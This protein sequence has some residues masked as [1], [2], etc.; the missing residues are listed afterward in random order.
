[1]AKVS[2]EAKR[3]Y[4]EKIKEHKVTVEQV[5]QREKNLMQTAENDERG[6]SYKKLHLVDESLNLVSS[7][8][9]MNNLSMSLLGIRNDALLN[10][11]RKACYKAIISLE[12]VVTGYLDVPYSDYSEKVEQISA[13][14]DDSRWLMTRKL[15]FAID[16]VRDG[17]GENSKWK[18]AFVE[19]EGRY[20]TVAK[21]LLDLKNFVAKQDPR[22]EGYESRMRHLSLIKDLL[23]HSADGYRQKY[24]LSTG[25]IDDFKLAIHYLGALRRLHILLGDSEEAESIK[26][27]MEVWKAKMEHD[28]KKQESAGTRKV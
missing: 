16:A 10:D 20:A 28:R 2:E 17:F 12:D 21:N 18:W 26:K 13:F 19:I 14:D 23:G 11:A 24:E 6:A 3:R 1:V 25:R 22:I 8:V 5:L 15:G 7:F 9:L 27:K 4:F